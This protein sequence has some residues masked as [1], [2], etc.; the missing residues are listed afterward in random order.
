MVENKI[1]DTV[2]RMRR[3]FED[4]GG[5]GPKQNNTKPE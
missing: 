3:G 2:E 5:Y 4:L 1:T